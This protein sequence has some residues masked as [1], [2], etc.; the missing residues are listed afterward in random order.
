MSG[1]FLKSKEDTPR[2]TPCHGSSLL[3]AR[4]GAVTAGPGSFVILA[5]LSSKDGSAP[6]GGRW[7]AASTELSAGGED[8]RNP[9]SP[10]GVAKPEGQTASPGKTAW[11][12][13]ALVLGGTLPPPPPSRQRWK[14]IQSLIRVQAGEGIPG[15]R[16]VG[17]LVLC[18]H[19]SIQY[20]LWLTSTSCE[21]G[22]F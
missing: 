18:I 14:Y 13:G 17:F 21:P 22:T 8:A 9:A 19:S 10:G 7:P 1:H 4:D 3:P 6:Q 16:K 12:G 15:Q 20:L 2:P 5:S 11:W